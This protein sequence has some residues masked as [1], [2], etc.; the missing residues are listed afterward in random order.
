MKSWILFVLILI[1]PLVYSCTSQRTN[2]DTRPNF[3]VLMSDNHYFEHLGCY[4]D[5]MVQTPSIDKIA[6]QGVRFT[7]AFCASPSCTPARG[8]MLTG[9]EIW[10]LREGANLWSSLPVEIPT[11]QDILKEAGYF[12]GHDRKGWGPGDYEADR[13][14]AGDPTLYG[15]IDLHMLQS[16]SPAKEYMMEHKDDPTVKPLFEQAFLKRPREELFDLKNDPYQMNNV[17]Y[18]KEYAKIKAELE[19]Q[20]KEYLIS[21]GDPRATG[22]EI[23]WDTAKYYKVADWIGKPRIEAQEKFGLKAEY[24]KK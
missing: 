19:G 20:L 12:I 11:Y 2:K 1:L 14:P 18:V 10:R 21:T 15:D 3:L 23:I 7:N 8:V 22:G 16:L 6:E 24:S 17:A 5:N 4:G 9:Q 13:L